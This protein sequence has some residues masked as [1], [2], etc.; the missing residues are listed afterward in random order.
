MAK[1][2]ATE[3]KKGSRLL[4]RTQ[5]VLFERAGDGISTD[6]IL[7]ALLGMASPMA[8]ET[9]YSRE[10]PKELLSI[11][12]DFLS[13]LLYSHLSESKVVEMSRNFIC[14]RIDTA[15]NSEVP[16]KYGTMYIPHLVFTDAQGTSI[17]EDVGYKSPDEM[18][19]FMEQALAK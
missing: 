13:G 10:I 17:A 8:E 16:T 12:L 18:V 3:L 2:R 1:L 11:Y 7:H 15:E 4:A 9:G 6:H 5:P 19:A 14:L